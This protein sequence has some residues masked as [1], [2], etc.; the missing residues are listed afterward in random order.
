MAWN[1]FQYLNNRH[2]LQNS[3]HRLKPKKVN[4]RAYWFQLGIKNLI[5]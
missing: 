4:F 3:S 5:H 2:R 1:N